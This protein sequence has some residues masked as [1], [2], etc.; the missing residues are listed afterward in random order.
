MRGAAQEAANVDSQPG[1]RLLVSAYHFGFLPLDWIPTEN[2]RGE[3]A[4]APLA[5]STPGV[6]RTR[7]Q[8]LRRRKSA[9]HKVKQDNTYGEETSQLSVLLAHE[10]DLLH[11]CVSWPTLPDHIKAA[12]L[13]LIAA[14]R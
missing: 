11:L 4:G 12:V 13:A 2:S 8:L 14:A 5:L 6:I 3:V 9:G 10:P 1:A 7:D